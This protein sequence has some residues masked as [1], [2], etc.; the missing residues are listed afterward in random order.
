[1]FNLTE[2]DYQIAGYVQTEKRQQ[3][4]Q[5]RLARSVQKTMSNNSSFFQH[6]WVVRGLLIAAV[7]LTIF[8]GVGRTFAGGGVDPIRPTT[9]DTAEPFAEAMRAY[10]EGMYALN[11]G[12][13]D[14]AVE[15]LTAAVEGIPAEV[16]ACVPAYQDMYWTLGEAQEAAGL[17]GQALVSYQRWLALAGD[18]AAPWTVVKVQELETQLNTMIVADTRL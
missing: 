15:W 2:K 12:D 10:R 13:Y 16:M 17:A 9:G 3:A 1:M 7:L 18:E 6:K 8:S 11:H 14:R 4:D 5:A